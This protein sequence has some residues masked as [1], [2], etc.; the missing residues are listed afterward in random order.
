MD[1]YDLDPYV[2]NVIHPNEDPLHLTAVRKAYDK[3]Q[4]VAV[5]NFLAS[6]K[7]LDTWPRIAAD[8]LEY[9]ESRITVDASM[10]LPQEQLSSA[11]LKQVI[12]SAAYSLLRDA[13][14]E[15]DG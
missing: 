8:V 10:D 7:Y 11:E 2:A 4:D 13:F 14:G 6:H 5:L 9:V 12:S 3:G 15:T 1:T